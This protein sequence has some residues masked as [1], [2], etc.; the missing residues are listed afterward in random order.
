MNTE[1]PVRIRAAKITDAAET[2]HT[3]TTSRAV[4]MPCLPPQIRD[5]EQVT[6][7]AETLLKSHRIWVAV[8]SG[9]L[10]GYAALDGNLLDT[11]MCDRTS[12]D[13]VSARCS[14]TR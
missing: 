9:K 13:R 6:H 12:A 10:L 3:H 2:S 5:H 8:R 4:S 11:C 1:E 14:W 7:W